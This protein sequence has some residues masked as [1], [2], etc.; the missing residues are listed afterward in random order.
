MRSSSCVHMYL[1]KSGGGEET[2]IYMK[3]TFFY[4]FYRAEG[5]E[6]KFISN[7]PIH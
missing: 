3:N 1:N 7:N 5:L 2:S 6:I 4:L